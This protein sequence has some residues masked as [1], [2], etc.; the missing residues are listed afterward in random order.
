MTD[1]DGVRKVTRKGL[2]DLTAGHT[3]TGARAHGWAAG[4]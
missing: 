1:T 4:G 2:R 3:D